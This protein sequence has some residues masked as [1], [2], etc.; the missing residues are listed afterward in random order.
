MSLAL[1]YP[2]ATARSHATLTTSTNAG[3][4][5]Q[6]HTNCFEGFCTGTAA[7]GETGKLLTN[8][9]DNNVFKDENGRP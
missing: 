7:V 9:T 5:V 3:A 8:L 1:A 2:L 4:S 6:A